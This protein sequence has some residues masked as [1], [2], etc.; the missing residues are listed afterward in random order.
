MRWLIPTLFL[1]GATAGLGQDFP[2]PT[3]GLPPTNDGYAPFTNQVVIYWDAPSN[4]ESRLYS[5]T[6]LAHGFGT[7]YQIVNHP[8]NEVHNFDQEWFK[9]EVITNI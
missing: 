4:S 2:C 7:N 1:L 9:V 5:T 3:C 6:N 8:T